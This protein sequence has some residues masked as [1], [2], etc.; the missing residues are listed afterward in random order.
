MSETFAVWFD[1]PD[2]ENGQIS[3]RH[4]APALLALGELVEEAHTVLRPDEPAV[5][6]KVVATEEG[7]FQIDLVAM[8]SIVEQVANLLTRQNIDTAA[9]IVQI[10]GLS[11]GGT[12]LGLFSLLKWLRGR[13]VASSTPTVDQGV[14]KLVLDDGDEIE[15]P[16][17]TLRLYRRLTIRKKVEEFVAPLKAVGITS[18]GFGKTRT[19]E[20]TISADEVEHF[21]AP[22]LDD[23][24][25]VESTSERA[26][27]IVSP[28]FQEGN[29]WRFSDGDSTFHARVGDEHFINQVN[30]GLR[31]SKGDIVRVELLN[32]QW[33]TDEGL[34]V[35][36]EIV[37]V[38][39]HIPRARQISIPFE[40]EDG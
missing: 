16:S 25:I 21:A 5:T 17:E 13:K 33:Q 37:Q 26:L 6:L 39:E 3:V 15:I 38:L 27:Q 4:L 40:A 22:Q 30:S 36:R 11:V 10:L 28:V 35:E 18:I 12:G 23:E 1:G 29:K 31:F 7:S 2:V 24:Q 19:S 32:R 14:V 20:T 9:D 34:K 8:E